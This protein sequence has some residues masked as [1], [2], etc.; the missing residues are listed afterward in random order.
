MKLSEKKL[1][2]FDI[3]GTLAVGD[4]LLPE[5][6]ELLADIEQ[7]IRNGG[8][9]S[10][11]AYSTSRRSTPATGLTERA[12]GKLAPLAMKTSS[13]SPSISQMR[14]ATAAQVA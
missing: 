14:S 2:L 4:E 10:G 7:Y 1:F 13:G 9:P 8:P 5:S 3:D 11:S 6:R 12:S